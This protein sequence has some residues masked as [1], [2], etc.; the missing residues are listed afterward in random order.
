MGELLP[1]EYE[2]LTPATDGK[3]YSLNRGIDDLSVKL[4][5]GGEPSKPGGSL[6]RFLLARVDRFRSSEIHPFTPIL[7]SWDIIAVD[8]ARVRVGES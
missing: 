7:M 1:S 6:A 5:R 2:E 8:Q 4:A 3:Q